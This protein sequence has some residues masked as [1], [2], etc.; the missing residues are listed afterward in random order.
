MNVGDKVV[1]ESQGQGITR[2]KVGEIIAIVPPRKN[3]NF[4]L[5][6]G[7]WSLGGGTWGLPRNHESYL[8]AVER[9]VYWPR[10]KSLRQ[11]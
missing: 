3:P 8:V 2:Q 7:K 9:K 5:P 1:W 10:V 11:V 4:C 6:T